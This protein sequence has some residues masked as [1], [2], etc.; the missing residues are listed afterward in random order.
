MFY[1]TRHFWRI[2]IILLLLA[3][4][5]PHVPA[6]LYSIKSFVSFVKVTFSQILSF[7]R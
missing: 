3:F 6:A 7:I 4:I 2:A 1:S 5:L